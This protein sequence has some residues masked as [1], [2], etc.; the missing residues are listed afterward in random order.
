[1]NTIARSNNMTK[2]NEIVFGLKTMKFW[3]NDNMCFFGFFYLQLP[4][5]MLAMLTWDVEMAVPFDTKK[6]EAGIAGVLK[7]CF[8]DERCHKGILELFLNTC[9]S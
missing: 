5:Y 7:V 4:G 9:H 6:I 1:M 8:S 2:L 3:P